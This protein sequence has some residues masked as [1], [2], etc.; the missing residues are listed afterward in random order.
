M[1]LERLQKVHQIMI[2]IVSERSDGV[3][4]VPIVLR[5]EEEIRK[6]ETSQSEYERILEMAR[7]A[8]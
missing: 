1:T 5:I 6:R 4:Y 2:R 7:K 8:A 3:A